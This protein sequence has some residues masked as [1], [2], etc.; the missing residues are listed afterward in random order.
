MMVDLDAGGPGSDFEALESDEPPLPKKTTTRG[1]KTATKAAAKAPV[2]KTPAKG[3]GRG[4]KAVQ[5][6][7]LYGPSNSHYDPCLE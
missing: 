4:K 7:G 2:K 5:V 6:C 1:K 3:R